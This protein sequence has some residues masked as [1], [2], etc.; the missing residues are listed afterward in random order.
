[1]K[2]LLKLPDWKSK[3]K[4]TKIIMLDVNEIR[5]NPYQPRKYF[6][7]AS[8][9]ELAN[10]IKQNGVMQ[11]ISVRVIHGCSYE[12]VAGERRLRAAKMADCTEIPA[13]IIE[14][15][16]RESAV[17]A[18]VENLQRQDLNF[19]EEAEGYQNLME[20]YGMTQEEIALKT[21]KSQSSISNKLRILKLPKEVKK[22][23]V[24]RKLSERHARALLRLP[25]P[26][27]QM[28]VLSQVAE[29]ELNVKKTEELVSQMQNK[30][31]NEMTIQEG[32]RVKHTFHDVRL[33]INTIRHSLEIMKNSGYETECRVNETENGYEIVIDLP[34]QNK[35][36]EKEVI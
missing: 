14:A 1:M 28:Y 20:D 13:M 6:D 24:D 33:F 27:L 32:Q 7:F 23:L 19:L 8:L 25:D 11:P 22:A 29:Q 30:M 3:K 21:G 12:L 4:E 9:Q 36:R 35:E 5:P 31:K 17:Y 18:L 26:E 2:N 10:S 34:Y 15:S 16:D